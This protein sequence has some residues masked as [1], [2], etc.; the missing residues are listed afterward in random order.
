MLRNHDVASRGEESGCHVVHCRC[1]LSCAEFGRAAA[2][3]LLPDQ[4]LCCASSGTSSA[5]S[6]G[7]IMSPFTRARQDAILEARLN[8][9][10]PEFDPSTLAADTG[11][12]CCWSTE[13]PMECTHVTE[14]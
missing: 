14:A 5:G 3:N 8:P 2:P 11:A 10:A 1:S 7:Q 4:L 9:Q 12:F 6:A 13:Q